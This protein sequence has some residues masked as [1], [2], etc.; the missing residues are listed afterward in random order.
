MYPF[1]NN[2]TLNPA[3]MMNFATATTNRGVP[4]NLS[5]F[6][7]TSI[8]TGDRMMNRNKVSRQSASGSIGSL[9]IRP[10]DVLCGRGKISFNH[11]GNRRFRHIISQSIDEYRQAT[12]KWEKSLV[13]ARLVSVIHASGGRFLKQ[14]KDNEDEW[15]ELSA[16]ESKSKVSHAIRDAIAATKQSRRP[17]QE[18]RGIVVAKTDVAAEK[19]A[20]ERPTVAVTTGVT[21]KGSLT[22]MVKPHY[23]GTWSSNSLVSLTDDGDEKETKKPDSVASK[24]NESWTSSSSEEEDSSDSTE[25]GYDDDFVVYIQSMLGPSHR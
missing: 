3:A 11:S 16:S 15:Y 9:A 13:A 10:N 20:S 5:S 24:L 25:A 8:D 1:T 22:K 14:K 19:P 21:S 18:A 6:H 23:R 7:N 2:A 12:S 4:M 17:S